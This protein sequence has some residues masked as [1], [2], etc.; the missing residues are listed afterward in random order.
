M[1]AQ[2]TLEKRNGLSGFGHTFMTG[3]KSKIGILIGLAALC[4]VLAIL[5]DSFATSRNILSVLRQMSTNVFLA[6][7]MT[8]VIILGCIDL[9]VG[10]VI[11]VSAC[12]CAGFIT[13]NGMASIVAIPLAMGCGTLIGVFNGFV[14]SRTTIPSF[15]VTLATMNIGR[16]F[17][18]VYT[19]NKTIMVN[20]DLFGFIGT[21]YFGAIPAPVVFMIIIIAI[22]GLLLAYSKFGRHIYAVG[23][24]KQAATYAGIN[25]KKVTFVVFILAA[26]FASFAGIISASRTFSGQ[27]SVGDGAEM[28]AIAAVILGGTSMSGGVG[29]I[30]GTIIGCLI[31]A[32]LSN[33]MN[34][35]AID[36]SMQD[37]VKGI[38]ILIAV[39]IDFL[40]KR[41]EKF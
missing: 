29:T 23:D 33:G 3:L 31:I 41:N 30:S 8:M 36:S 7:G 40:K 27:F 11:A 24:N 6:C 19:Q 13:N 25:A 35:L 20:D 18:K 22:T 4:V 32:I 37:I 15:I 9:S 26:L 39:T 5:T 1:K 10:S 14:V 12:L 16:G 2:V 38:V 28:D 21:G 17:V 34:L